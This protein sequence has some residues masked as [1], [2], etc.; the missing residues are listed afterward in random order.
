MRFTILA[1][2]IAIS[3]ISNREANAN[4]A[5]QPRYQWTEP[6]LIVGGVDPFGSSF[7]VK[8]A[9]IDARITFFYTQVLPGDIYNSIMMTQEDASGWITS[10]V[11]RGNA[12]LQPTGLD[13]AVSN[14]IPYLAFGNRN[15]GTVNILALTASG[16]QSQFTAPQIGG[17][18]DGRLAIAAAG[19][20]ITAAYTSESSQRAVTIIEQSTAGW[21][22]FNTGHAFNSIGSVDAVA[23]STGRVIISASELEPFIGLKQSTGDWGFQQVTPPGP[24]GAKLEVWRDREALVGS[25]ENSGQRTI[26]FSYRDEVGGWVHE[27]V[28]PNTLT[29]S[30][31]LAVVS[32]T[33]IVA[34]FNNVGG[35]DQHTLHVAER[36]PNGAWHDQPLAPATGHFY[37]QIDVFE[38]GGRPAIAYFNQNDLTLRV[39]RAVP[40]ASWSVLT[41]TMSAFLASRGGFRR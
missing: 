19:D 12:Q 2:C 24:R 7:Q 25:R 34:Y 40:E 6:E 33:P 20:V 30:E 35:L 37:N 27:P 13:V 4:A 39:I 21:T 3:L 14:E 23:D 11:A 28:V 10:V 1:S 16:W 8:T 18:S 22:S 32:D 38:W 36:L 29:R 5:T 31:D 26:L 9:L 41:L 17:S 15:L